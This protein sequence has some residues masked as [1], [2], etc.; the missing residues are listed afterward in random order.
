MYCKQSL[1]RSVISRQEHTLRILD[2]LNSE[3]MASDEAKGGIAPAN[4]TYRLL[5][6]SDP[7]KITG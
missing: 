1:N 5:D 4:L 2:G 6:E 7:N 3:Q